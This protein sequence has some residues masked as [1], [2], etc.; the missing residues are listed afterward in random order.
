[1]AAEIVNP[2]SDSDTGSGTPIAPSDEPFDPAFALHRGGKMA[3]QSTVPVRNKDDLSLAYTPGVAKVCSAIAERPELVHD[4]TWKSQV[5]A[6]VTDGTAVLG[7]GDIGPEASLPVMEGK[8]ILFKQFGGVDAVPIALA[9]TDTDEIVDT[10]VRLAPSFGGVNL[11]DI[12]APRCFE[13]ERRLQ[14]RLDIPVFHDDQHGTAIVT[15]A[16]LRNA[17]KLTGRG[18]GDL[19]AVISA[20]ARRCRHRQVP[21]GGRHQATW[22]SRTARASSAGTART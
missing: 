4:Y 18:L 20:R 14:E 10:V 2:H 21:A 7:L 9:T 1:M 3:V 8:A 16:A 17:A 22:R 5:V 11:E 13:I 19:R 15:L 6:V 12:S